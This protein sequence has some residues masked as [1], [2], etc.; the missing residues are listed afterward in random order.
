MVR[1]REET[2]AKLELAGALSQLSSREDDLRVAEEEL[3]R[4]LGE[5]RLATVESQTISATE[6]LE[7]QAFLEHVEARRRA[8]A[9]ELQRQ[10]VEVADRDAELSSAAGE[11]EM[12]KR[13]RERQREEHEREVARKESNALDELTVMRAG[14]ETA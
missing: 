6:L 4:A 8:S 12:L 1:E 2:L 11:H 13:L 10:T 3:E 14:Q 5:Q 9:S 7:R